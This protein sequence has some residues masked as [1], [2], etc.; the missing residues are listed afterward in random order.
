MNKLA[1]RYPLAFGAALFFIAII[2]AGVLSALLASGG[3]ADLDFAGALARIAVGLLLAVLFHR[4]FSW[5]SSLTGIRWALP[6]LIFVVWNVVYHFAIGSGALRPDLGIAVVLGLAPA[7]FEEVI[8]RGIVIGKLRESG[9][10]PWYCVLGSALLFSCIH[11]TNAMGMDLPSLL[12]QVLYSFVIGLVFGAIYFK[13]DDI[14]SVILAHAAID[15]SNNVFAA[16]PATSGIPMMAA[17]LIVLGIG[18]FYGLWLM[19]GAAQDQA[20]GA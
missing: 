3:R 12:V 20:A 4:S 2:A 16:H 18:A 11:L 13:T 8:F 6:A 1:T 10:D 17:F 19:R 5:G 9:K 15:I 7:I 14:V